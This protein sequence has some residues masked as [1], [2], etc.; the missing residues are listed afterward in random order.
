MMREQSFVHRAS[1]G[2]SIQ[3][4]RWLP[5]R[6]PKAVLLV[7]HGMAEHGARYGRLASSATDQGWAV[8]APD[9]RGHGGTAAGSE[10]GFLGDRDGFAR[11]VEDL[12]EIAGFASAEQPRLPLALLGH[13]MGSILAELYAA[14]HGEE[15]LCCALSG[16]VAPAPPFLHRV[17]VLLAGLGCLFKGSRARAPLLAALSFGANNKAFQPSRT[18]FDWLSRD[19]AEVDLYVED[20]KCGF[21]CSVGLYRD[22]LGALS[23]LYAGGGLVEKIPAALPVYI[24]AGSEDPVGGAKGFAGM[25]EDRMR[26]AG[27]RDVETRLYPGARH[28]ILNETNRDEVTADL[29]AW[30][31]RKLGGRG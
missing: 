4:H 2:A 18:A 22:L 14:R 29:L 24:M 15:L 1:D 21:V 20:P 17:A 23:A 8:Y 11:V 9:H 6:N 7:A 10:L 16:V 27:L 5:D 12:H 19:R 25:L 26:A 30:L 31:G 28:E 13:S 3:I